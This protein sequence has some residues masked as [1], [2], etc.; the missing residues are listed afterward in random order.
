MQSQLCIDSQEHKYG[1]TTASSRPA[2]SPSSSNFFH[3]SCAAC[4][5]L[6]PRLALKEEQGLKCCSKSSHQVD[7]GIQ[8]TRSTGDRGTITALLN[9]E[10]TIRNEITASFN[11]AKVYLRMYIPGEEQRRA[12]Q[13]SVRSP[14]SLEQTEVHQGRRHSRFTCINRLLRK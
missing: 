5:C 2:A 10:R 6:L 4:L 11:Q 9:P 12:G 13:Q 14:A 7:G 3:K 1:H 8:T